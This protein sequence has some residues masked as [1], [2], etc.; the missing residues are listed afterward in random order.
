MIMEEDLIFGG[1]SFMSYNVSDEEIEDFSRRAFAKNLSNEYIFETFFGYF[2]INKEEKTF[3]ILRRKYYKDFEIL[4]YPS[5]EKIDYAT[6]ILYKVAIRS[7]FKGYLDN[8]YS[9]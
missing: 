3:K 6:M 7:G 4:G 2:K 5:D 9:N 8:K 1:L